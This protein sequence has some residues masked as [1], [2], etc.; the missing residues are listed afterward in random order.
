MAELS[1][2][3]V[4]THAL[5]QLKFITV[6]VHQQRIIQNWMT[7]VSN[8]LNY[9]PLEQFHIYSTG[10]TFEATMTNEFWQRIIAAHGNRLT[11]FSVHRMLISLDA[12]ED[13]CRRCGML[14][15]LFVVVE[16]DALVNICLYISLLKN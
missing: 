8:L 14:E 4:D 16:E 12:I 10:A 1:R 15:E 6:T 2:L 3:C 9:S 11:R 13:I 5:S 7:D